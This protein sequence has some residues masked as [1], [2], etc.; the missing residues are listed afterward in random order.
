M[1]RRELLRAISAVPLA[2]MAMTGQAATKSGG[3]HV[4]ASKNASIVL[5]DAH[6]LSTTNP[7]A[8]ADQRDMEAL[9]LRVMQMPPVLEARKGVEKQWRAIT[10]RNA[11]EKAWSLFDEM[12][13]E[14]MF[15]NVLKAVNSDANYPKVLGMLFAPPHEWFGMQVPGSRVAGPN[16][17]NEYRY[18]PIDAKARYEVTGRYFEPGPGDGTFNLMTSMTFT[19]KQPI[20]EKRDLKINAD[21]TFVITIG[22]ESANGRLNHLQTT[23]DSKMLF[24]RDSR[25]DWT[26]LPAALRIR[27]LDPPSAPPLTVEQIAQRAVAIMMDDLPYTY[28]WTQ[29]S[30]V[31][32]PNLMTQPNNTGGVGGLVSQQT[33]FGRAVLAED[34]ALVVTVSPGGAGYRSLIAYDYWYR[35]INPAQHVSSYANTQA[36]PNADGTTTYVISSRDPGVY[37]WID[38]AGQDQLLLIHRW[39][40]LPR[41]KSDQT[42]LTVDTRLVNVN[43]LQSALP[44]EMRR[45][46]AAERRQQI[47]ERLAQFQ[48][49]F[50]F[51]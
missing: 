30:L 9:A 28:W 45:V 48:K 38:A 32:E 16:S 23:P 51:I 18:M 36:V 43:D 35:N 19:R 11:G 20:L 14:Y 6:F 31:L 17:D 15:V 13:T 29:L 25:T 41:E 49:K 46:S 24:V 5:G 2:S 42:R 3:A 34:E 22:P 50:V 44:S 27:R 8:T 21:G 33:S 39:Q 7:L 4:N 40:V 10:G 12:I 47:D 1:N 37:N 26:Q